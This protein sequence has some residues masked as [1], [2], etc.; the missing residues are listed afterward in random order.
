MALIKLINKPERA[1]IVFGGVL[2]ILSIVA[3]LNFHSQ[4][5][6]NAIQQT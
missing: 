6:A 1:K 5:Y 2:Y 4:N 3:F